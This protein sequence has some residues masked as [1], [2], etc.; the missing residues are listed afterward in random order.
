MPASPLTAQVIGSPLLSGMRH[1]GASVCTPPHVGQAA[2]RRVGEGVRLVSQEAAECGDDSREDRTPQ[3]SETQLSN[4]IARDPKQSTSRSYLNGR[5][6]D[7]GRKTRTK[8]E[9]GP[10][11]TLHRFR[12]ARRSM[13][14]NPVKDTEGRGVPRPARDLGPSVSLKTTSF[15]SAD[16][17]EVS[18]DVNAD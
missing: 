3:E 1:G 18:S 8:S 7:V 10:E 11:H 13:V 4:N 9:P 5:V 14:S 2:L 6:H 16:G 12:A 15:T 17:E